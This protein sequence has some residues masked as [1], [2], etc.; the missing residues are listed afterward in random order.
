MRTRTCQFSLVLAAAGILWHASPLALAAARQPDQTQPVPTP[1]LKPGDEAPALK[2][3]HWVK[4]GPVNAFEKGKVYV[5]E[6][7]ATWCIPCVQNIPKLTALQAR[8]KDDGLIV[9]GVSSSDQR[10]V[11]DV[12]PFVQ[13]QGEAMAYTVG[14][15]DAYQTGKAYLDA[16]NQRG[17]PSAYVIDKNGRLAWF[18]HPANNM[19]GVAELVLKGKFD[20]EKY[21][22]PQKKLAE[23]DARLRAAMA[24]KDLEEGERVF[25]EF[26]KLRP[27]LAARFDAGRFVFMYS[28]V[29]DK[30]KAVALGRELLT[31]GLNDDAA[32]LVALAYPVINDPSPGTPEVDFANAV[33]TRCVA[34]SNRKDPRMLT[35]LGDVHRKAGEYQK[36]IDL[37][38]EA[39]MLITDEGSR[40]SFELKVQMIEKELAT[41][42]PAPATRTPVAPDP[43]APIDMNLDPK[44]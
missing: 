37:N 18:G 43:D 15:D 21:E 7:W 28:S 26:K 4:G 29:G 31:T 5:V 36:A 24:K 35:L 8:H 23:L 10:G 33:M 6:F 1:T 3:A 32:N 14:V 25:A 16:T 34:L 30:A 22:D 44:K 39:M 17:I 2:M 11:E 41:A 27:E 40:K 9:I 19:E 13:K 42:K 12:R 38:R 20:P